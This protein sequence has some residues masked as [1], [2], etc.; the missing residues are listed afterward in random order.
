MPVRWL[1]QNWNKGLTLVRASYRW[2]W[3]QW[4]KITLFKEADSKCLKNNKKQ[5]Q[6]ANSS[7]NEFEFKM[8]GSSREPSLIYW[9]PS[10]YLF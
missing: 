3:R 2:H 6:R 4:V 10:L 9:G 7:G 5:K 8:I 1:C